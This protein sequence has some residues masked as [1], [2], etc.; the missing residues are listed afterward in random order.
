[1]ILLS[2]IYVYKMLSDNESKINK[3][4]GNK[5]YLFR[6]QNSIRKKE[7]CRFFDVSIQQLNKYETGENRISAAKLFMFLKHYN[8]DSSYF[9]DD[10]DRKLEKFSDLLYN[11]SRLKNNSIKKS[12]INLIKIVSGSRDINS[13]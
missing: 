13:V 6:K 12:L 2:T 5:L 11:F 4:I 3:V 9:L 7:I 10:D 8:I 1:M